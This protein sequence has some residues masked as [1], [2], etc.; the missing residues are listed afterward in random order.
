MNARPFLN[1]LW[2]GVFAVVALACAGSSS[3]AQKPKYTRA[4][5]DI[6]DCLLPGQVRT[7]GNT[8]YPHAASAG[9][10]HGQ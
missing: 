5:L 10:D 4:D 1:T 7:L 3:A 6:V 8:P 2:A 9:E